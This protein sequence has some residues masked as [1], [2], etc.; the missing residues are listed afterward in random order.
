M[1]SFL[2]RLLNPRPSAIGVEIGTSAIKVVALRPGSPPVLLHA[3]MMP[4]PIGSMRDGLVVEPQAVATE[5][6]NLLAEH[7]ITTSYAVTAVP[8]QSA[9][10]RNIMV[11]QH[12]PQG[13]SGSHQVGGGTL[14][15]VPHRRGQPGL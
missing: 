10:T 5:L 8:N 11:P 13:P 3:V 7:R 6:S 9:V 12:G 15:S 14:H 4:T 1:S 2:N